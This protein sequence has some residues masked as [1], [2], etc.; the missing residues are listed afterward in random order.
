MMLSFRF[1]IKLRVVWEMLTEFSKERKK[2]ALFVL[3]R[4]LLCYHSSQGKKL[5]YIKV[6]SQAWEPG[7]L[8]IFIKIA[9]RGMKWETRV[10]A[11][12]SVQC[13]TEM[14]DAPCLRHI[15]SYVLKTFLLKLPYAF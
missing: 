4:N 5:T 15:V 2:F 3:G 10:L 8:K 13:K 1:L 11:W 6:K 7:R 14:S 9:G 12:S